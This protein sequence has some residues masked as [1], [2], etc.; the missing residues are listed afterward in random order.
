MNEEIMNY[1]ETEVIEEETTISEGSGIGK[2]LL[3]GTALVGAG[4]ALGK[5]VP[6]AWKKIKSKKNADGAESSESEASNDEGSLNEA[7]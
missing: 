3:V 1:E 2:I 7:K 6:K 4:I 5:F